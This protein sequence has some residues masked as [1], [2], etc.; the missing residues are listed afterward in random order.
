M[1][2]KAKTIASNKRHRTVIA[3]LSLCPDFIYLEETTKK[4]TA[5]RKKGR[6][7]V[8]TDRLFNRNGTAEQKKT[9]NI[10]EIK[11]IDFKSPK[12]ISAISSSA[13]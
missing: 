3:C 10:E 2:A 9:S 7:T 8:I 12:F 6:E 4:A 11:L 5:D 13:V 1:S